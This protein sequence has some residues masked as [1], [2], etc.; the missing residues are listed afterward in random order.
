MLTFEDCLALCNLSEEEICAIAE[1][2]HIP[3]ITAIEYG[4]YLVRTPDG[5]LHIRQIIVEDIEHSRA[6]GNLQHAK[7]LEIVLRHFVLSHPKLQSMIEE[8]AH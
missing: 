7:D 5:E 4:D 6:R 1:H 3:E 2:E 8:Q